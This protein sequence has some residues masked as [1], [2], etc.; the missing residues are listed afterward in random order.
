[1]QFVKML[2]LILGGERAG[3]VARK[4]QMLIILFTSGESFALVGLRTRIR[5]LSP[6]VF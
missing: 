1:M 4:I 2:K 5:E 3:G 6:R